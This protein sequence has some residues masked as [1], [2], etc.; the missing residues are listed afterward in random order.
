MNEVLRMQNDLGVSADDLTLTPEHLAAVIKWS[1]QGRST[2]LQQ[3]P[4]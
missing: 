2:L 4:Y 1:M 3:K